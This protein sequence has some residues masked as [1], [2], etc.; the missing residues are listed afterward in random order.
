MKSDV[1]N[2][3]A[4]VVFLFVNMP[5]SWAYRRSTSDFVGGNGPPDAGGYPASASFSRLRFSLSFRF[6]NG[7]VAS[8]GRLFVLAGADRV[9]PMSAV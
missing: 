1:L 5:G 3:V 9:R 8:P 7:N 4:T 6:R 2:L